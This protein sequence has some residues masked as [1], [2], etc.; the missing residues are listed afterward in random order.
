MTSYWIFGSRAAAQGLAFALA[1]QLAGLPAA[2]QS[3]PTALNVITVQ[4]DG[5]AGRVHQRATADPIIRV[6]DEREAPIAGAAVVFT[7]P[8]EGATGTFANGSRT[9]TTMTDSHGAATAQGLRF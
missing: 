2:G 5:S 4:G 9:S 1:L 7:L 8:T 6:L 3:L